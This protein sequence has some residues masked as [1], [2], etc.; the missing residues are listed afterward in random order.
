M[1]LGIDAS[2]IRAGGGLTHLRELMNNIELSKTGFEK[3]VLWSSIS[4]LD[5][6]QDRPWLEKKT[7]RLMNSNSVAQLL[8]QLFFFKGSAKR[9]GCTLVFAP[10][11]TFISGFRPY[12]TLS[13]NMLPFEWNETLRFK[14]WITRL[15]F[16]VLHLT[17]SFT[18]KRASGVIFLTNYA[19]NYISKKI[20]IEPDRTTI[21]PHGISTLFLNKPKEQKEIKAYTP[22]HPYRLL[23]VSIVTVYKHQWNVARAVS[24]LRKKGYPVVLDLVGPKTEEGFALLSPVMKSEDPENKFIFFHGQANKEELIAFYQHADAFVFASSCENMPI[25]L[26]EAMTAGLPIACSASGPMPEVL[27]DNGFYFDP[28]NVDSITEALVQLIENPVLRYQRSMKVFDEVGNYTWKDCALNTFDYLYKV[29]KQ[30][31]N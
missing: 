14:S 31:N 13:Q 4:T 23:Y 20:K 12:V 29:A 16:L 3:V 30:H 6:I 10:G 11:S 25:I 17:Q 9:S 21:I 19:R 26:I 24:A 22:D 18:F 8:W 1:I 28:E 27:K 5:K 15:R 7:H 2:N